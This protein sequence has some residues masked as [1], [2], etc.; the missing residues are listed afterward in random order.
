MSTS[1]LSEKSWVVIPQELRRRYHLKKGDRVHVIDYGG[2]ISIVPASGDPIASSS[3]MLKGRHRWSKSWRS[4]G[5]KMQPKEN[6][7]AAISQ[8]VID[9]YAL[10][11]YLEGEAGADR[12]KEFLEAAQQGKCRLFM[13]SVN[14]GEVMYIVERER[15]IPKA[16]E[17]LARIDELPIETVDADRAL[18]LAAAHLKTECP[19]AYT[20]CFAAALAMAKKA[21]LI[22]RRPRIPQGQARIVLAD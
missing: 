14:L 4:Q 16:Q 11:A 6:K 1:T 17:T 12:V 22:Y 20:D 18:T 7:P 2:V 8:Y 15:G 21:V 19:I 9:S 10:L 3:G 13:C 5:G